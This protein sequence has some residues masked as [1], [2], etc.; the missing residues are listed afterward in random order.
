MKKPVNFVEG[1]FIALLM[2]VL[3]ALGYSALVWVLGALLS[4]K[5]MICALSLIYM[6]YVFKRTSRSFARLAVLGW[7][8]VVFILLIADASLNAW[9]ISQLVLIWLARSCAHYPSPLPA[10]MD[11][12]LVVL[13]CAL[14]VAVFWQTAWV[15]L[16]VWT[17]FLTQALF[18]FIPNK[19]HKEMAH[20]EGRGEQFSRA[21]RNAEAAIRALSKRASC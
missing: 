4:A 17:F 9:L 14:C 7:G 11:L 20:D 1:V 18:C 3:A 2:S 19:V 8:V 5:F 10:V 21:Y 12:A 16:A 13:G 6:L 15:G